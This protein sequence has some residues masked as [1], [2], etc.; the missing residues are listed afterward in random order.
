MASPSKR[1]FAFRRATLGRKVALVVTALLIFSYPFPAAS[2]EGKGADKPGIRV[3]I[4]T[5]Q[6][7]QG[8]D[9]RA[10]SRALR[11]ILAQEPGV[12][13]RIVEDIEFLASEAIF[14]YSVVVIHFKNYGPPRREKAIYE[15]LQKFVEQGGG[16]LLTHFA[17]GAF[18][19]WPGF[20]RLAGRVWDKNKRPHDPHGRFIVRIVDQAHPITRGL[21]D[22][23]T[24]DELYTCLGGEEAITVLAI[25]R[26]V[27]DGQNYPMIFVRE[28]GRGRVVHSAL[29]HDP[30]A[31]QAEV[32]QQI[33]RRAVRWLAR[34]D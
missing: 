33:L 10:T 13:A 24:V 2:Q 16:L 8:H 11:E 20:V 5:G 28:V 15:N 19:E 30:V 31:Y 17:C 14:D 25:A 26:S 34:Q 4:V 12:D 6:D 32:Y 3:L 21:K 27:V 9:W 29:G 1:L 7:Y 22:F 18:E 23:E